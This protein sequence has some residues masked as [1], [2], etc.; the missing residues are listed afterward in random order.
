M[1]HGALAKSTDNSFPPKRVERQRHRPQV[2]GPATTAESSA[3]IINPS[4]TVG[5]LEIQ[6]KSFWQNVRYQLG[7]PIV[8]AEY[9]KLVHLYTQ[10]NISVREFLD[11]SRFFLGDDSSLFAALSSLVSPEHKPNSFASFAQN[12]P[13]AATERFNPSYY[14]FPRTIQPPAPCSG[15]DELCHE[16]L[17]DEWFALPDLSGEGEAFHPWRRNQDEETLFRTEE[18]RHEYDFY[19]SLI[20][21]AIS[22]MEEISHYLSTLTPAQKRYYRLPPE[23]VHGPGKIVYNVTI[24]KVYGSTYG[25]AMVEAWHAHPARTTSTLLSRLKQREHAWTLA[26]EEWNNVWSEVEAR[27]FPFSL[28]HQSEAF[29]ASERRAFSLRTFLTEI[30]ARKAEQMTCSIHPNS[31]WH[32]SYSISNPTVL[33]DAV[34]LVLVF[35][36]HEW[37]ISKSDTLKVQSLFRVL[38]EK[39]FKIPSELWARLFDPQCSGDLNSA[40]T[41]PAALFDREH[42]PNII[43]QDTVPG[44]QC[45]EQGQRQGKGEREK[46]APTTLFGNVKLYHFIRLFQLVY[47]RLYRF[48]H[49]S[50][51]LGEGQPKALARQ[52]VRIEADHADHANGGASSNRT[53]FREKDYRTDIQW[54]DHAYE[55]LLKLSERWLTTQT[56]QA[57]YLEAVTFMF[58]R[59]AFV[60]STLDRLLN[61]LVR[62][63]QAAVSD[64]ATMEMI[65]LFLRAGDENGHL[66]DPPYEEQAILLAAAPVSD[67]PTS[68]SISAFQ[69]AFISGLN[70]HQGGELK[71]GLLFQTPSSLRDAELATNPSGSDAFPQKVKKSSSAPTSTERTPLTLAQ[72]ERDW[73]TYVETFTSRGKDPGHP[74]LPLTTPFLVRN[75]R[76][77]GI[78]STTKASGS[79]LAR[80]QVEPCA[81]STPTPGPLQGDAVGTHYVQSNDLT[82]RIA[83][84]SYRMFFESGTEDLLARFRPSLHSTHQGGIS[85][86]RNSRA[87]TRSLQALLMAHHRKQGL[88]HDH[89]SSAEHMTDSRKTL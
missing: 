27:S 38:L 78:Q 64:T 46:E 51:I 35:L 3:T 43:C 39:F 14:R 63:A 37:I 12:L 52:Q 2:A 67:P 70:R 68:G 36:S 61:H 59:H 56:S 69:M 77:A 34:R 72:K 4:M 49:V 22:S 13:S 29:H 81:P 87:R 28:D 31:R 45:N 66:L 75:L 88:A 10:G 25:P 40:K 19:L 17:N 86:D 65:S 21:R 79:K 11:R 50:P 26:K 53:T 83:L 60:V 24:K 73:M 42:V 76:H 23:V 20:R 62:A 54:K 9:L 15:R 85:S 47:A 30:D 80:Q 33:V 57:E 84:G 55:L 1:S 82:F 7:D 41:C 8:Y 44:P 18:E 74:A 5:L 6:A 16:V 32:L 71:L 48:K 89:T 58:P